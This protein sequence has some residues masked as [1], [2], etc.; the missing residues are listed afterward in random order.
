MLAA[1]FADVIA[2]T[3][4]APRSAD[5]RLGQTADL[6]DGQDGPNTEFAF[7]TSSASCPENRKLLEARNPLGC[8]SEGQGKNR[9]GARLYLGNSQGH[10]DAPFAAPNLFALAEALGAIGPENAE[11]A[12]DVYSEIEVTHGKTLSVDQR[13][14][15]LDRR[16]SLK[17]SK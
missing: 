6:A 2:D 12:R 10:S 4:A 13:S 1:Q 9:Q 14:Q 3:A 8:A 16:L 7:D 11:Q 15:L 5:L 17:C